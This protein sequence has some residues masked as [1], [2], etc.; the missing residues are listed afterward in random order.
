MP[1]L[2][3]IEIPLP[4]GFNFTL[5]LNTPTF[6]FGLQLEVGLE[7]P[8]LN[9]P[10]AFLEWV[11]RISQD[12]HDWARGINDDP[13][14]Y[15]LQQAYPVSGEERQQ[16]HERSVRVNEDE[17]FQEWMQGLDQRFPIRESES[18]DVDMDGIEEDSLQGDPERDEDE[19]NMSDVEWASDNELPEFFRPYGCRFP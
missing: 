2:F 15:Y 16:A 6:G 9:L 4:G 1:N 14:L 17:E 18:V 5:S 10:P 11:M 13:I 12:W 3:A 7:R 8:P 19:V